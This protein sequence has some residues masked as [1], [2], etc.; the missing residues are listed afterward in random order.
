MK[1]ADQPMSAEQKALVENHLSTVHW[2]IMENIHVNER[3]Y[4]LAYDDLFQEGCIWLCHAA[5]TYEPGR[6]SFRTYA[7]KVVRNGLLSYCRGLYNREK[8]S[9]CL[10]T[11]GRGEL[12][13]DG[14]ALEQADGFTMEISLLETLDLLESKKWAYRG[15]ARL[16]IEALE[17]KVRGFPVSEIALLY[18]VPAPHVGAWISRTSQKLRNDPEFIAD[19]T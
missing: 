3:I 1:K 6:A 18:H 10:L 13:A 16:G 9:G 14:N 8:Q 5:A 7:K 4:G 2:A 11:N 17:L 19:I 15:V 12:E